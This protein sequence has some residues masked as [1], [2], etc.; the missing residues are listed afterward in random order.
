MPTF[1]LSDIRTRSR[2]AILPGKTAESSLE[3]AELEAVNKRSASVYLSSQG[4]DAEIVYGALMTLGDFG[5]ISRLSPS[6]P[7]KTDSTQIDRDH[8]EKRLNVMSDC[9]GLI[10]LTTTA[11]SESLWLPW[12]CGFFEGRK[13]RIAIFPI[14]PTNSDVY[15]GVNYLG[16]YPFIAQYQSQ[17]Q[18]STLVVKFG[19]KV[20]CTLDTWLDG[21]GGL[22]EG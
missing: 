17:H 16:M 18:R 15:R 11:K 7:G 5:I 3:D 13:Q 2:L 19:A 14:T 20:Y 4:V 9:R 10:Y 1:S 12:E 8:Q 22:L 21:G 6:M